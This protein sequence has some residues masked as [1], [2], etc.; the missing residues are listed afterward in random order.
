MLATPHITFIL[1]KM[2]TEDYPPFFHHICF[3]FC[4]FVFLAYVMNFTK[5]TICLI[6]HIESI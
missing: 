4:F 1:L 2:K 5:V 6:Q 3:V